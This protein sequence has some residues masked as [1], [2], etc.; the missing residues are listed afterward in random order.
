[1]L[2][3]ETD[4]RGCAIV[5]DRLETISAQAAFDSDV[6]PRPSITVVAPR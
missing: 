6:P 3:P 5:V 4:A 1:V 2:L